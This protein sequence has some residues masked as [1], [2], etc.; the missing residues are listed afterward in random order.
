M[1]GGELKAGTCIE[2]KHDPENKTD[3]KHL[4][5]KQVER[6]RGSQ[7]KLLLDLFDVKLVSNFEIPG[8]N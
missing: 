7:N 4:N 8:V 2:I 6:V 3:F 1:N 5:N